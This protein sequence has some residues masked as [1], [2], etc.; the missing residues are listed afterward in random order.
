MIPKEVLQQIRRIEITTS[1]MVNDVFCGQ[2]QS[3]FKGRGI[4]FEEVRPYQPGDE[5]RTIDWNVTARLG[6]PYVKKF[7]E[8]RELTVLLVMDISG[9]IYFGTSQK[10]KRTLAAHICA[11]LALAAIRNNDKVGFLAF[12]DRVEEFIPPK[13]G[14]RHILRIIRDALYLTGQSKKTDIA[15]ALEYLGKVCKRKSVVFVIS[16]FLSER[17]FE[18]QLAVANKRHDVVAI[19]LTDPREIS[20]PDIGIVQFEDAETD[21]TACIDTSSRQIRSEFAEQAR[22]VQEGLKKTFERIG[23]DSINLRSDLPYN[24]MLFQFFRMR[25]RRLR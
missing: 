25:E 4:E 10:L 22:L 7:V 3:V 5:V 9:S 6:H 19:T 1:R 14:L 17:D 8:E 23:I 16:D 15:M 24:R 2:Y 18:K 11:L 13:K 12:S 20:I 21:V